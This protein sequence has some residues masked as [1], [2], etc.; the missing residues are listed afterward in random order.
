MSGLKCWPQCSCARREGDAVVLQEVVLRKNKTAEMESP[1]A[2]TMLMWAGCNFE[3]SSVGGGSVMFGQLNLLGPGSPVSAPGMS[4]VASKPAASTAL[5]RAAR[6]RL[7]ITIATAAPRRNAVEDA[8]ASRG[9]GG[10][11]GMGWRKVW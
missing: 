7:V 1:M 2:M 5:Q 10:W 3:T 11:D 4:H 6:P 9:S 8:R